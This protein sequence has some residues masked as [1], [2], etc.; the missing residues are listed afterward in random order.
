MKSQKRVLIDVTRS[1]LTGIGKYSWNLL[2][3]LNMSIKDFKFLG[4]TFSENQDFARSNAINTIVISRNPKNQKEIE[5]ISKLID[6]KS[7]IYVS[8]NFSQIVFPKVPIIQVVHDLIYVE[9]PQWQPTEYDLEL[10]HGKKLVKY[11]QNIYL[12]KLKSILESKEGKWNNLYMGNRISELFVLAQSNSILRANSLIAISNTTKSKLLKYYDVKAPISV[13]YPKLY[14]SLINSKIENSDSELKILYIANFEPRKNHDIFFQSILSLPSNIKKKCKVI[15]I[16]SYF[17]KSHY[18]SFLQRLNLFKREIKTQIYTN[19][20][21][22]DKEYLIQTSSLLFYPSLDEG[23]GIPL[24]EAMTKGLPIIAYD[25]EISREVCGRA[26]LYI[27]KNLPSLFSNGILELL[28]NSSLR[29]RLIIEGNKQVQK[30]NSNNAINEISQ[31]LKSS[32]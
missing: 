13:V 31:L 27:K 5:K 20:S 24:L 9:N 26:A 23:F 18:A 30:L 10:R 12:P 4:L 15:L 8:T 29:S 2:K 14:L 6:S 16:G 25:T 19:I 21:E 11:C 3:N 22:E 17:Y 28:K 1:P 7:D 32:L